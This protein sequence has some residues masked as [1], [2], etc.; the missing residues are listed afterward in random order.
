[1]SSAACVRFAHPGK[2]FVIVEENSL[3]SSERDESQLGY[4]KSC[5]VF[6]FF[7]YV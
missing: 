6:A 2:Y 3:Y 5:S 4:T 1:M 7:K